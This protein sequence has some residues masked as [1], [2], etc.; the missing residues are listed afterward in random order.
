MVDSIAVFDPG[1]R[2]TDSTGA[3]VSDAR[4]AFY[5]AGTSNAM[6]VYSDVDLSNALGPIVY[7]DADGAPVSSSGG[8][9]KVGVYVG[10]SAY[11]VVIS[12]SN[13]A[14]IETKDNQRGALNTTPFE[15]GAEALPIHP[16]ISKSVDYVVVV[17]DQ[18]KIIDVDCTAGDVSITL[19]DAV[20]VGDNW[21][22]TVRNV[23]AANSV[24]IATVSGQTVS[25][26]LPGGA[27]QSFEMVAYGEALTFVSN[28][29]NWV[30]KSGMLGLKLG[31]GYH[32]TLYDIGTLDGDS[33]PYRVEPE[34]GNFQ[35]L[36]NDGA[37]AIY[38]PRKTSNIVVLV[39]N[40]AT[41]GSISTGQF[42]K[43]TGDVI[44]TSQDN[45]FLLH[46]T[47]IYIDDSNW[48]SRLFVEALQ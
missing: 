22:V 42:T 21:G 33:G 38:P 39:I 30:V 40:G 29:A 24:I 5:D 37:F 6:T 23:G 32:A 46:V 41:A 44:T 16:V 14:V 26:P 35:Q 34:D 2:I 45:A 12:R 1:T 11:K 43:V 20:A 25:I 17:G 47:S 48:Y 3:P 31:S 7:C 10:T 28:G 13:G 36:I 8:N 18:S 15:A 19:P 9:T 27:K 4:I